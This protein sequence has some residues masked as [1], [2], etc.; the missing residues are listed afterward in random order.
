MSIISMRMNNVLN[1]S[2][3]YESLSGKAKKRFEETA[4]FRKGS[5]WWKT[6]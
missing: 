6:I 2:S 3:G 1:T 4:A 5:V